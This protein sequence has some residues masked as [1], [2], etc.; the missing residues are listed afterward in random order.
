MTERKKT[1]GSHALDA[2][3]KEQETRDPIQLQREAQKKYIDYLTQ[4][5]E[6][7]KKDY[8]GDF[9]IVVIT[10]KEKT[11]KN[12][13]RNLFFARQSCPTPDYDQ[14]VYQYHSDSLSIE[15]LWCIPD[16]ETSMTLK[17]N[18]FQVVKD[19]QGLLQHVLDFADG[20]L[21]RVAK[22]LNKEKQDSSIIDS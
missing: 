16:R 3:S 9:F 14:T 13:L 7:N 10:K 11:L 4:C 18:A 21:Y 1:V 2:M 17:E 12:V 8:L 5:V 15:Y 20:K 22:K 6:E 19:E